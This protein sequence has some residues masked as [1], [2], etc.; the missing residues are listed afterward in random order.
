MG[1]TVV[2][3]LDLRDET[4]VRPDYEEENAEHGLGDSRQCRKRQE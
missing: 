3:G 2:S 1:Q 4:G